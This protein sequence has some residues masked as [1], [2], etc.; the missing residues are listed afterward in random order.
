MAGLQRHPPMKFIY[1]MEEG[2]GLTKQRR[3]VVSSLAEKE[4]GRRFDSWEVFSAAVE[5]LYRGELAV[6]VRCRCGKESVVLVQNILRGK[7]KMCKRC[8]TQAR[9]AKVGHAVISG[10]A[11]VRVQKR[12]NA[13]KQRCENMKD[14]SYK[15]YG[16]RGIEFRF[17][18]V[19][20]AISYVLKELPH[21]TYLKLDIDRKDNNGHYEPGNLRLATR[22]ENIENRRVTRYCEAPNGALVP[23]KHVYH[24]LRAMYPDVKYSEQ[25]VANMVSQG[26]SFEQIAER[27]KRPSCKPKGRT[28]LPTPDPAIASLYLGLY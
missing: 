6:H 26:M 16:A 12:C 10:A 27:W 19:A 17:A 15:N 8:T 2:C 4:V 18:T 13:M 25:G 14:Q 24:V 11:L 23:R 9:H 5:R 1:K 28:I 7:S 3:K 20:E 22:T 21:P